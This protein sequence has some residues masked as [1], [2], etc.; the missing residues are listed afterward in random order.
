MQFKLI[1]FIKS[2][3]QIQIFQKISKYPDGH[4]GHQRN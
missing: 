3:V 4:Q 1:T 2:N